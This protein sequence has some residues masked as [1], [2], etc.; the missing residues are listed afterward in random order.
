MIWKLTEWTRFWQPKAC[1]SIA[2]VYILKKGRK[3]VGEATDGRAQRQGCRHA[4]L[5]DLG[6]LV[7]NLKSLLSTITEPGGVT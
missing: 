7:K 2:K 1:Q 6:F 3:G 5:K 4:F